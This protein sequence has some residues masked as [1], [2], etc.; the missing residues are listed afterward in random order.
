MTTDFEISDTLFQTLKARE[1][2][3]LAERNKTPLDRYN[4]GHAAALAFLASPASEPIGVTELAR[5]IKAGDAAIYSLARD[6]AI[7]AFARDTD[8]EKP[9]QPFMD[10][11]ADGLR[12]AYHGFQKR[13]NAAH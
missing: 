10:G 5:V 2:R 3:A 11:F 9:S 4:E 1:E 13:K 7:Y 6:A 12:Y 8:Y